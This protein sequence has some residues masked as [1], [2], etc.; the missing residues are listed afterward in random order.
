MY[1]KSKIEAN[2]ILQKEEGEQIDLLLLLSAFLSSLEEDTA[3]TSAY[4]KSVVFEVVARMV[5]VDLLLFGSMAANLVVFFIIQRKFCRRQCLY[6]IQSFDSCLTCIASFDLLVASLINRYYNTSNA[7]LC[8]LMFFGN[9]IVP[10]TFPFYNFST[11]YIRYLFLL[12]Q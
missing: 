7:F 10:V 5:L 4:V 11:A 3:T 2:Y 12:L 8:S 1:Y 6:Y 9:A